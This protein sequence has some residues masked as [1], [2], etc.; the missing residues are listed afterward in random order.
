M[1][2]ER[3][4]VELFRKK[5]FNAVRVPTSASSSEP[6]PDVIV[7][8]NDPP[9]VYAIEV[10][11]VTKISYTIAA[12]Q[13]KKCFDFLSFFPFQLNAE[14]KVFAAIRFLA[15][16]RVKGLWVLKEA[17]EVKDMVLHITDATDFELTTPSKRWRK[18]IQEHSNKP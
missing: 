1:D 14:R 8:R 13:L 5:G 18:R 12:D 2:A 7:A 10:K 9:C 15:G 17:T 3:K 16:E 11:S 4:L 6:F